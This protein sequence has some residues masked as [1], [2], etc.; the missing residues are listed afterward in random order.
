MKDFTRPPPPTAEITAAINHYAS[1]ILL[2]LQLA[3]GTDAGTGV[4]AD[5]STAVK[6]SIIALFPSTF[7]VAGVGSNTRISFATDGTLQ[8]NASAIRSGVDAI[9]QAELTTDATLLMDPLAVLRS[10]LVEMDNIY[11]NELVNVIGPDHW[12]AKYPSTY[13]LGSS[14]SPSEVTTN[15]LSVVL[16]SIADLKIA[17]DRI[18]NDYATLNAKLADILG[19]IFDAKGGIAESLPEIVTRIVENRSYIATHV[20]DWGEESAP[21]DPTASV[22]L[23]QNDTVALTLPTPPSGRNLA[24]WRL[25]R[26]NSGANSAAFQFVAEIA[27]GTLTY[28]DTVKSGDLGEVCPSIGPDGL[29]HWDEPATRL[30]NSGLISAKANPY[31][32]GMV[33]MPNGIMAGF[34]DN[35]VAFCDP[36]HPYAGRLPT[37]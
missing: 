22:E 5:V 14:Y 30:G 23:D 28:T 35:F 10:V 27:I 15:R 17:A 36:Y 31:L 6:A 4:A 7:T 12:K 34:V 20:T 19:N 37:K 13:P 11:T 33:G 9:L 26:T 8:A 21:C 29:A 25:Y 3:Y 2:A 1:R 16:K 24:H 18:T 32:R